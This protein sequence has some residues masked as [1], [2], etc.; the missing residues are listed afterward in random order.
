MVKRNILWISA[1][2]LVLLLAFGLIVL[3][4]NPQLYRYGGMMRGYGWMM[5]NHMNWMFPIGWMGMML[6]WLFPL[7]LLALAVIGI[8]GLV[9]GIYKTGANPPTQITSVEAVCAQCGKTVQKDWHNC[10]HCG[11]TL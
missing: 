7:G 3:F 4:S 5:G 6:M 2:S 1:G 8:I 10:P 9:A 11:N